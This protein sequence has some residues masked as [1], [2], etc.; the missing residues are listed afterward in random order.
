MQHQTANLNQNQTPSLAP[1]LFNL[2]RVKQIRNQVGINQNGRSYSDAAKFIKT[3][4]EVNKQHHNQG[5]NNHQV[6]YVESNA[7]GV[8]YGKTSGP[9]SSNDFKYIESEVNSLFDS[10]IV[11]LMDKVRNF[12]PQYR[13]LQG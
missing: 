4:G 2:R 5:V 7:R 3:Q 9:G 6:A 12:I 8:G 13:L 1:N 10:S 11:D